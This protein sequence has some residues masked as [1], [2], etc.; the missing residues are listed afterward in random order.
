MAPERIIVKFTPRPSDP[1]G[2]RSP[3]PDHKMLFLIRP[4]FAESGE[5]KS[6]VER[7]IPRVVF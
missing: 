1:I 5:K 3:S 4:F 7:A 2:W 6:L